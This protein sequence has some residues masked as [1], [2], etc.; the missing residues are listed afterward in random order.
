MKKNIFILSC[1][2]LL[3]GC[4]LLKESSLFPLYISL[5]PFADESKSAVY[6][7]TEVVGDV[8]HSTPLR[9]LLNFTPPSGR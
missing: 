3:C 2:I 6:N 8:A 5:I 9:I 4:G 1:E 7:Q